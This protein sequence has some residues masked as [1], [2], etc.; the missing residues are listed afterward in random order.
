MVQIQFLNGVNTLYFTNINKIA[1]IC[2]M[3]TNVDDPY[4][5]KKNIVF[6]KQCADRDMTENKGN[7]RKQCFINVILG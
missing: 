3:I 2:V 4:L 6:K 7:T 5:R 1:R